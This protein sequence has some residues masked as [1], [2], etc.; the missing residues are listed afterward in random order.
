[1]NEPKVSVIMAAYNAS[2]FIARAIKSVLDQTYQNWEL[3]VVDDGSTDPTSQVVGSFTDS[4]IRY[5]YQLNQGV[6]SARNNGLSVMT[7]S[8]FCFLD[9]DDLFTTNSIQS[10]L[11]IFWIH[12]EIAFVDG[13]VEIYNFMKKEPVGF[14]RP[15]FK[16]LPLLELFA[17]SNSCFFGPTWMI[18]R[19]EGQVYRFDVELT[20]G[21]DLDFYVSIAQS[22][23]FDFTTEKIMVY[24]TGF[25]SAMSDLKKLEQC[26]L[27]LLSK[28]VRCYKFSILQTWTLKCKMSKI[29]FLSYVAKGQIQN[30]LISVYNF[31]CA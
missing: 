18:R 11:S 26:Y 16:G 7:G 3:I 23:H 2:F 28:W 31:A 27:K 20:H 10:R 8:F 21:E 15:S 29:M 9:A 5:M 4:R 13:V 17:L 6:S 30:S 25:V 22:G 12:E 24:Q 1:M 19:K 14:Y